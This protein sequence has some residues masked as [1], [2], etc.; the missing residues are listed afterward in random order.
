[1]TKI[2]FQY[3]F[4]FFLA[5]FVYP[6]ATKQYYGLFNGFYLGSLHGGNIFNLWLLSLFSD[7]HL[8]KAV[9]HGKAYSIGWYFGI[10]LFIYGIFFTIYKFFQ[11][12]ES[13]NK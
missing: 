12:V 13:F 4:A 11:T 3:V 7:E 1:M 9:I 8:T 5:F 2:F 10:I 6:I